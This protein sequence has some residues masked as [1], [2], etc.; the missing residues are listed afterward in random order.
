MN[1]SDAVGKKVL[2]AFRADSRFYAAR[3]EDG[4]VTPVIVRHPNGD[5]APVALPWL[6]GDVVKLEEGYAVTYT[7]RDILGQQGDAN[8]K[9]F[10]LINPDT[11]ASITYAV[12]QRVALIS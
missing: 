12:E 1:L 2:V 3:V 6:I 7:E 8:R 10:T 4:R 9:L 5:E 11:V